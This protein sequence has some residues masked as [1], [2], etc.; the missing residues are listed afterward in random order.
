LRRAG[1]NVIIT[2]RRQ[3]AA[4]KPRRNWT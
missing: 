4:E 1:A 2:A 3:E